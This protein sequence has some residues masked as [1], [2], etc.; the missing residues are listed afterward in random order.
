M[1]RGG[2]GASAADDRA[3]QLDTEEG[4]RPSM[5]RVC[6]GRVG[7]V[8]LVGHQ[9]GEVDL[10]G[11]QEIEHRL[12]VAALGPADLSGRIVDT[13]VLV[14]PLVAAGAVAS[15]HLEGQLVLVERAAVEL[16]ADVADDHDRRPVPDDLGGPGDR[17][18]R[19]RGGGDQHRIDATALGPL[20]DDPGGGVAVLVQGQDAGL[21]GLGDGVVLDV[22]AGDQV[23]GGLGQAAG[24]LPDQ[25]EA[26]HAD[27]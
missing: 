23:A 27:P 24:D 12:Q 10:A 11:G 5:T 2:R 8:E 3:G 14:G 26:D 19:L 4:L 15:G 6:L 16:Q 18:G 17:A 7:Q 20:T 25:A 9:V 13:P 21:G 1:V 22:D